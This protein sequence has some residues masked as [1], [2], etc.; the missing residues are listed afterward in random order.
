MNKTYQPFIIVKAEEILD[1][2]KDDIKPSEHM[3]ERLCMI[4]TEKFINGK[5]SA[6]DDV[7]TVFESE[8]ELLKFVNECYTYENLESLMEQGLVGMYE[9]ENDEKLF[10]LTEKGKLFMDALKKS[11]HR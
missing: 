4:L 9:D 11:K 1:I 5:L 3:K 6:D 10:F 8:E 7:R 2:L